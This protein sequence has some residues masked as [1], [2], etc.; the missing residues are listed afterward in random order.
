M[1]RDLLLRD[2]VRVRPHHVAQQKSKQTSESCTLFALPQR[3]I[4]EPKIQ[5][6]ARIVIVGSSDAGLAALETLSYLPDTNFSKLVLVS[7]S[8][9]SKGTRD[10]SSDMKDILSP[11][12]SYSEKEISQLRLDISA[13]VV[14]DKVVSIDRETKT[15]TT[16]QK[17]NLSY[18]ILLLATGLQDSTETQLRDQFRKSKHDSA[19][20]DEKSLDNTKTF[21]LPP[22]VCFLTDTKA[23]TRALSILSE[24]ASD[25]TK[26][27]AVYV[28][29]SVRAREF[30]LIVSLSDTNRNACSNAHSKDINTPTPRSNTTDTDPPSQHSP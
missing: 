6:N 15:L 12:S 25:E 9:M 8:G 29:F 3:L 16:S 22:R 4:S 1:S 30:L 19:A 7:S 11:Y 21:C 2:F 13:H 20:C 17:Q 14:N 28:V 18:D 23:E 26:H 27:V 24:I 10:E 5:C